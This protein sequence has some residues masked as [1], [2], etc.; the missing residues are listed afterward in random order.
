MGP[1]KEIA[2]NQSLDTQDPGPQHSDL[3]KLQA[4]FPNLASYQDHWGPSAEATD[5]QT[6]CPKVLV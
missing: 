2:S 1:E 5:S 3:V 4:C 6:L